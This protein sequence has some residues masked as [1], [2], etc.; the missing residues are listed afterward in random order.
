MF[1][2]PM[3]VVTGDNDNAANGERQMGTQIAELSGHT[4]KMFFEDF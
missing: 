4:A 2:T 1:V 3:I